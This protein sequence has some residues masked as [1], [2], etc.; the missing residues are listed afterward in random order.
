MVTVRPPGAC[1]P[2]VAAEGGS[3]QR[4]VAHIKHTADFG[5]V[6]TSGSLTQRLRRGAADRS[7]RDRLGR[8]HHQPWLLDGR[9]VIWPAAPALSGITM[10]LIE[11]ALAGRGLASAR[12]H[13][14]VRDLGS[15]AG[16]FVT[17]ARGIAPVGQVDDLRL[18]VDQN[19]MERLGQAYESLRGTASESATEPGRRLLARMDLNLAEHAATCTGSCPA[20]RCFRPMTW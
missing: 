18:P 13:I 10:Q 8:Q 3:Y 7:G 9:Q 14:R 11:P 2:A 19:L 15:F 6:T 1:C 4:P 20:R 17:N 16:V 12:A 5:S